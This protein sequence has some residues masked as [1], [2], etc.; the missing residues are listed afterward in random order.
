MQVAIAIDRFILFKTG[1]GLSPKTLAWYRDVLRPFS[2]WLDVPRDVNAITPYDIA[3]W[4]VAERTRGLADVTVEGRYRAL[5]AFFNW[6]EGSDDIGLN[7]SPIGHGSHK[8]IKRP[9]TNVRPIDFVTLDD[10][11]AIVAAID[12]ADWLDYRDY[13]IC[14]L[15]FWCGLRRGELLRLTVNDINLTN[16]TLEIKVSKSRRPRPA[17]L[18]PDMVDALRAYLNLRPTTGPSLWLSADAGRRNIRGTLSEAGLRQMLIRRCRRAGV[19][20]LHTHLWRHGFAM[21]M[22]NHGNAEMSTI[23][24]LMGHTSVKVTE[25]VYARH[26][27]EPLRDKYQA[28]VDAINRR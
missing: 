5:L 20:Y 10:Y 15:L 25:S 26:L 4:L 21:S 9:K 12:L 7:T 22:L 14:G 1:E 3:S 16:A 24:T 27:I 6:C 11:R 8:R 2:Q 28:A 19:R 13:C 23:S 17:L 18:T